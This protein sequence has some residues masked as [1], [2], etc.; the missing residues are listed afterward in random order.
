MGTSTRIHTFTDFQIRFLRGLFRQ[1]DAPSPHNTEVSK[2]GKS[3]NGDL[4]IEYESYGQFHTTL[5]NSQET[6]ET[7]REQLLSKL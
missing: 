6:E 2:I 7:Y 1:E 4:I 5:I 3:D